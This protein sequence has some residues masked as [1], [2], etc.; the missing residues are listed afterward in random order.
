[1]TILIICWVLAGLLAWCLQTLPRREIVVVDILF[2]GLNILI[3][4]FSLIGTLIW[5][6][7]EHGDKSIVKW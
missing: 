3:G 6:M 5:M 4:G 7:L 2:L 1:M